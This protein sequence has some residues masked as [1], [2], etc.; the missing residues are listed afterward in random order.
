MSDTAKAIGAAIAGLAQAATAAPGSL[1]TEV[2]RFRLVRENTLTVLGEV[3]AAQAEWSPGHGVWSM[4]QI[5][6]HLL[7]TE[8]MYRDQFR[9]IIDAAREGGDTIR[10]SLR[11][12]DSSFAGVPRPVMQLFEFPARMMSQFMP[13]AL[14]EAVIRYPIVSA[15]NPTA[16]SPR[17]G[18]EL[19]AV[20]TGL[21]ASLVE[22]EKL[23]LGP[24]PRNVER[25]VIDHPIMGRTNIRELF[26][27]VIVHEE[28]HQGQI[29]G[30]RAR[31]DFP[32][33]T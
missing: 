16:S 12:V 17:P 18:L 9:Q 23:L 5:A 10:V 21:A 13:Q 27:V 32:R 19:G 28:R 8:E 2:D 24:L 14:R 4:V 20:R 31:A 22:T 7:R 33:R 1:A 11:D 3:S 29:A 15:V 25:P 6:D 26:R 30:L